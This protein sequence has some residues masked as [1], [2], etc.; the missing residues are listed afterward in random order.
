MIKMNIVTRLPRSERFM[1][2]MFRRSFI[3]KSDSCIG[4]GFDDNKAC[5]VLH[6][7]VKTILTFLRLLLSSGLEIL[8]I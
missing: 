1:I 8:V 7:G 3:F 4:F 2:G 6:E 5:A